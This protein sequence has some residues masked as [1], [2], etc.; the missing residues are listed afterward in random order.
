MKNIE[1]VARESLCRVHQISN[2]GQIVKSLTNKNEIKNVIIDY[3]KD[4]FQKVHQ[5]KAYQDKIYDQL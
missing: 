4:H 5:T 1:R 2:E 3:N